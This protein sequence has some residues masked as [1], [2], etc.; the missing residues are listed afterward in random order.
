MADERPAEPGAM[1]IVE[2]SHDAPD[3]PDG[4]R[5]T[6]SVSVFGMTSAELA[7]VLR[8]AADQIEAT[9]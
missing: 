7:Y 8:N 4:F 6:T 5:W 3:N 9:P 2:K 1:V